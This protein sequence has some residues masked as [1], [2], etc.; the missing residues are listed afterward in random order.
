MLVQDF[1]AVKGRARMHTD[2]PVMEDKVGYGCQT[3]RA[4]AKQPLQDD[5]GFAAHE[6]SRIACKMSMHGAV[7]QSDA[8]P[9]CC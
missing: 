3:H 7:Q 4:M 9:V 6:A 2:G 1:H 8:T 5:R